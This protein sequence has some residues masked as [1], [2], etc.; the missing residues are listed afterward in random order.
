[1]KVQLSNVSLILGSLLQRVQSPD[2]AQPVVGVVMV[3]IMGVSLSYIQDYW[4]TPLYTAV[5][6]RSFFPRG[7][8]WDEGFHQILISH[9]N[10]DITKVLYVECIYFYYMPVEASP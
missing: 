2:L 8:L 7:F 4:P 9:W 1:M 6:S 5:P 3:M 10:L